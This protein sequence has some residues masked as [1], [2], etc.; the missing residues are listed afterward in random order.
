MWNPPIIP[1]VATEN[2]G[3]EDLS[4]AIDSYYAFQREGEGSIVRRRAIARW[5]LLE[6]LQDRLLSDLLARNGTGEKLDK[7]ASDVAEKKTDPYSA[8]D[9]ILK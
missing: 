4:A 2:K 7:L 8:V 6:M 9:E 3:I 1:T 5:R